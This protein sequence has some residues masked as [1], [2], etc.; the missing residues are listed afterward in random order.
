MITTEELKKTEEYWI[1]TI[2]NDIWRFAEG[3]TSIPHDSVKTIKKVV[4][5]ALSMG[6]VPVVRIEKQ[7]TQHE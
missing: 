3:H 4:K 1:E 6:C 7:I 2:E 5:L